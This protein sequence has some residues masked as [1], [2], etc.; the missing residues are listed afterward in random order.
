MD[1][2]KE[3]ENLPTGIMKKKAEMHK[4]TQRYCRPVRKDHDLD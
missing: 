3:R 1:R 2:R 4:Q